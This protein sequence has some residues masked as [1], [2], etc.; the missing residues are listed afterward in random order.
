ML[1]CYSGYARLNNQSVGITFF[2]LCGKKRELYM[3]ILSCSCNVSE[4]LIPT[5]CPS[6]LLPPLLLLDWG[7]PH[8]VC[9]SRK[10]R[11]SFHQS[12]CQS[13]QDLLPFVLEYSLTNFPSLIIGRKLVKA[14]RL[15]YNLH[16]WQIPNLED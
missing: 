4:V 14:F 1:M 11:C 15:K 13:R 6:C 5:T 2:V 9:E 12:R 16:A 10:M 8:R 3:H 7:Y